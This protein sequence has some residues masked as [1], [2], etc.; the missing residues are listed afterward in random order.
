MILDL[1]VI[2]CEG[3]RDVGFTIDVPFTGAA[4]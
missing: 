1:D 3:G 2:V 4:V